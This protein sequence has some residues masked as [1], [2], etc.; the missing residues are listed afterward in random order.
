[1][2]EEPLYDFTDEHGRKR[3]VRITR[4]HGGDQFNRDVADIEDVDTKETFKKVRMTE[5][6][7][8]PSE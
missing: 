8:R 6:R 4:T 5:L 1:M 3:I 2:A 7:H